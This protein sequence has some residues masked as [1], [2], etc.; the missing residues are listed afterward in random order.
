MCL[1]VDFEKSSRIVKK[2]EKYSINDMNVHQKRD[3][4]DLPQAVKMCYTPWNLILMFFCWIKLYLKCDKLN[5][6]ENNAGFYFMESKKS[7]M[8]YGSN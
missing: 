2:Q 1:S 6:T 5:I 8:S 3:S 4:V 7:Q